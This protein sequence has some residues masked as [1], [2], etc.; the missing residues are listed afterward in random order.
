MDI[1]YG[2]GFL[3]MSWTSV[4]WTTDLYVLKLQTKKLFVLHIKK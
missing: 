1:Y 2:V 4:L 3:T